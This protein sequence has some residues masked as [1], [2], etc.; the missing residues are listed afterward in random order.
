MQQIKALFGDLMQKM[1][2]LLVEDNPGDAALICATLGDIK[3]IDI[4]LTP[5][6]RAGEAVDRLTSGRY[7]A[8][9]LDMDLPDS[10]G[11][12]TVDIMKRSAGD[13][14]IVV[15]SGHADE[16]LAIEAVRHG[17]Q[18]YVIKGTADGAMMARIIR[19]A[20][21]R[22]RAE[23]HLRH[24]TET[25]EQR[26]ALRTADLEQQIARLSQELLDQQDAQLELET[27]QKRPD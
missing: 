3:S 9:L 6:E 19:Y 18:D 1:R 16:A 17:A 21:E 26:V 2:V 20:V 15:L 24:L 23:T 4:Q 8:I 14:P 5:C 7:D 22:K 25:L 13:L 27:A 12:Q 10:R 11:L